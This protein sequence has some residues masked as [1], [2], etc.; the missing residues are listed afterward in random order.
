MMVV[1]ATGQQQPVPVVRRG[2]PLRAAAVVRVSCQ[3][4][5][6][7]VIHR[8]ILS[9]RQAQWLAQRRELVIHQQ[10]DNGIN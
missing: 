4:L 2:P 9:A 6:C 7:P 10:H 3:H 8:V 1:A 5:R